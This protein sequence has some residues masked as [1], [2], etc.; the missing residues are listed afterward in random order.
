ML[1]KRVYSP[2]E[3]PATHISSWPMSNIETKPPNLGR[4]EDTGI[5]GKH[6]HFTKTKRK[7]DQS[8]EGLVR[9]RKGAMQTPHG[10]MGR[11]CSRRIVW[12]RGG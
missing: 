2:L 1:H 6:F 8:G 11:A 3:R 5:L 12:V 4:E 9:Q 7:L 10:N